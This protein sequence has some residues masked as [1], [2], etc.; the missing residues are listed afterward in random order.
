MVRSATTDFNEARLG[1]VAMEA[2]GACGQ[3]TGTI[4]LKKQSRAN[5]PEYT[6]PR[7]IVMKDES[8]EVS[9]CEF[10]D[11]LSTWIP[12]EGLMDRMKEPDFRVGAAK[13]V[14]EDESGVRSLVAMVPFT[15]EEE[16]KHII[17]AG[18]KVLIQHR[19]IIL[20]EQDVGCETMTLV[21]VLEPGV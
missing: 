18:K 17:V 19:M 15:G 6:G 16:V 11:F 13:I 2:C 5:A 12:H 8:G 4:I 7:L 21:R 14:T 9:R 10:C 1:S 20:A 3:E